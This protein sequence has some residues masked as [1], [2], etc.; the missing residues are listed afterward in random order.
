M[1][2][3]VLCIFE[4]LCKYQNMNG[5]LLCKVYFTLTRL[6]HTFQDLQPSWQI[7]GILCHPKRSIQV[8][9]ETISLVSLLC[10]PNHDQIQHSM[11]L[12]CC[13]REYFLPMSEG[14]S[15][16]ENIV[17]WFFEMFTFYFIPWQV[18]L[19]PRSPKITF[20]QIKWS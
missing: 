3:E 5:I 4:I 16:L 1:K 18:A 15:G 20:S 9:Q 17:N 13:Q 6:E 8:C 7:L 10:G 12:R 11:R 19:Q 2:G 14:W